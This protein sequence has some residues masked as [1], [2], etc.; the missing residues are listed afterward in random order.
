MLETNAFKCDDQ[1]YKNAK[2][3]GRSLC[4]VIESICT[5]G[6]GTVSEDTSKSASASASADISKFVKTAIVPEVHTDGM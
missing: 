6:D 5:K 2:R 1:V 3:S 4:V